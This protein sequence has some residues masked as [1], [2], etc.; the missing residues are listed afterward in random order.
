MLLLLLLLLLYILWV[1][2]EELL[3]R[4]NMNEI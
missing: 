4:H 1:L 3:E 2:E